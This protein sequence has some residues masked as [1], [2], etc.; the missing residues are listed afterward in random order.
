VTEM[1]EFLAGLSDEVGFDVK[2][3]SAGVCELDVEGRLVTFRYDEAN[4]SWLCFALLALGT[5]E[6]ALSETVL[7][8]ALELNL[9][10]AGTGGLR[11]GLFANSLILSDQ[12]AAEG[13]VPTAVAERL[14]FLARTSAEL[15]TS[16]MDDTPAAPTPR[17]EPLGV[18]C[19]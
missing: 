19:V 15:V 8:R 12:V 2:P 17:T 6:T 3:D 18:L 16:L 10:G 11:L 1:D 7:R 5:G 4:G 13:L 14:L 9:F